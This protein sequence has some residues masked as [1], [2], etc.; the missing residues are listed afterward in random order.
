MASREE[1]GVGAAQPSR[2]V[3]TR[4]RVAAEPVPHAIPGR[5]AGPPGTLGRPGTI[6]TVS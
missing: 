6:R 1:T 2:T 4:G 5:F 3:L